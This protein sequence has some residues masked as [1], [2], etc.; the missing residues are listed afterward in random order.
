[1][2]AIVASSSLVGSIVADNASIAGLI[3]GSG[4]EGVEEEWSRMGWGLDGVEVGWNRD[5]ERVE[6]VEGGSRGREGV[7]GKE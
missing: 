6:R 7:V 5:G 3:S 2:L 4:V 1:L